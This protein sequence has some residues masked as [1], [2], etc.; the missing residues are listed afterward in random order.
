MIDVATLA[1]ALA[2]ADADMKTVQ[3]M[4]PTPPS[5]SSPIPTPAY[6]PELARQAAEKAAAYLPRGVNHRRHSA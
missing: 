6:S 5:P 3:D 4:L 1:L 2:A